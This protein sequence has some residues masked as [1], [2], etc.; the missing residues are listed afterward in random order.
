MS[1][2][3]SILDSLYAFWNQLV[4]AIVNIRFFDIIDIAIMAFIIYKAVEF[5]RDT[6]AGQLVRGIAFLFIAFLLS[7]AFN[8]ASLKWLL[9]KLLDYAIIILIV[10]FQPE[11][12]KLL[13]KV[14]RSNISFFGKQQ[15]YDEDN[16]RI[17]NCIFS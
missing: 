9:T 17:K 10:I 7:V 15:D 16:E 3:T 6:R 4:F 8:L 1:F 11:I 14:G 12:R 5:L 13:E 2:I